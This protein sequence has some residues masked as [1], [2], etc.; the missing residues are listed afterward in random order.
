MSADLVLVVL[1]GALM[2]AG[3]AGTLLPVIPGL[4]LIW[5]SGAVFGVIGGFGTVGW[6][7]M[8][9]LTAL[10]VLG[11]VAA[12]VVPQRRAAADEVA[13]WGQALAIVLSVA[14]FF[15]LP[16]VGAPIGFILGI[17]IASI[18]ATRSLR[19]AIPAAW[20]SLKSMIIV[21]GLQLGAGFAMFLVWIAWVIA[22]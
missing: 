6:V 4:W 13:W 1:V 5:A 10:A 7:A 12:Y 11:T 17:V 19:E 8:A 14:G 22:R 3:V 16:V 18:L 21:S 9:I 20:S 2:I 15:L